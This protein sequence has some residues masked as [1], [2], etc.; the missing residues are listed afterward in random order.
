MQ[1]TALNAVSSSYVSKASPGATQE[2]SEASSPAANVQKKG[3][4]GQQQ[5]SEKEKKEVEQ[6]KKRDREVRA[7]ELAHLAAAGGYALGGPQ[8]TFKLGPDGKRYAVGGEVP[9]DVSEVPDNPEATL[10]K[11]QTI[12]RAALAPANPSSA[13]RAIAAK[14][15]AMAAKARQELSRTQEDADAGTSGTRSA[16]QQ[17]PTIDRSSQNNSTTSTNMDSASYLTR[18]AIQA[19]DIS[20]AEQ[21]PHPSVFESIV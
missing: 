5:L 15:M 6:L 12:R 7:H 13:D 3:P 9:I 1:I 8:F 17:N 14:A 2:P 16:T 20:S 18:Q 21:N 11:A 4:A 19:Y 10:Q